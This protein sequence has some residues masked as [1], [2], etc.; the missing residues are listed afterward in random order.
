[1]SI[2]KYLKYWRARPSESM[3][4]AHFEAFSVWEFDLANETKP[5]RD[6]TWVKPVW[7]YPVSHLDNRIVGTHLTLANGQTK[8]GVLSNVVLQDARRTA[9]FLL[10][11]FMEGQ[12]WFPLERYFDVAYDQHGPT[13]LA[14]F[15]DLPLDQIFPLS[16][17]ISS[18]ARGLPEVVR[19][20]IPI[21][22]K[23]ILSDEERMKLILGST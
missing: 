13:A 16:Y 22:P 3:E 14:E 12:E 8:F 18:V 2:W 9:Q 5:G 1:M 23:E 10:V 11:Q 21:K 17:D 20:T 15:L 4:I 7:L 6:E 19:G